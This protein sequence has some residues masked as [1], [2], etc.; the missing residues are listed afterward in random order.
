M[1]KNPHIVDVFTAFLLLSC[2]CVHQIQQPAATTVATL[3]EVTT[4][5]SEPV[6]EHTTPA[7]ETVPSTP[8][9][10]GYDLPTTM[11][12][13]PSSSSTTTSQYVPAT[14]DGIG[15]RI[16]TSPEGVSFYETEVPYD[17][18]LAETV[19]NGK[20]A[21][22]AQNAPD[23][24]FL[25]YDGNEIGKESHDF[26]YIPTEVNGKLAYATIDDNG[27]WSK[28]GLIY[29]SKETGK[30][31]TNFITIAD[32][33]G[34]LAYTAV[35]NN[36]DIV[37]YD[38]REMGTEYD[39]AD[40]PIDLNGKPAYIARKDH[41]DFVVWDGKEI[42]PRYDH[43]ESLIETDGK[44]AYIA[45]VG[46]GTER[47]VVYDGVESD[48]YPM[49]QYLSGSK[50][51]IAYITSRGGFDEGELVFDGKVVVNNYGDSRWKYS[52]ILVDGKLVYPVHNV[53]NY[54]GKEI[55]CPYEPC[56]ISHLNSYNGKLILVVTTGHDKTVILQE[57]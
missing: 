1:Y 13:M 8:N 33:G 38:G 30:Q 40:F 42:T 25:V 54:N 11:N 48:R 12:E 56:E 10:R 22:I 45:V 23:H 4:T 53:I 43:I 29:D 14:I 19:V 50:G 17:W 9:T 21:Y 18:L 34:K 46:P 6:E 41:K 47:Y 20:L 26:Y 5:S 3:E 36:T 57:V 7:E 31:Y 24:Y 28:K 52:Y 16:V 32:V 35:K 55:H 15:K 44:L 49:I 27:T 2:G 37:V 51:R 39:S